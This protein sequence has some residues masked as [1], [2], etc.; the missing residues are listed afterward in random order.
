MTAW[1]AWEE[2]ALLLAIVVGWFWAGT[3]KGEHMMDR[4]TLLRRAQVQTP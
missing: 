2:V 1:P 4:R 3:R